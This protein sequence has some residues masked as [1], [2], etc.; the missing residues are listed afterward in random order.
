MKRPIPPFSLL[1]SKA[2]TILQKRYKRSFANWAIVS[3]PDYAPPELNP[4]LTMLSENEQHFVNVCGTSSVQA[5]SEAAEVADEIDRRSIVYRRSRSYGH[6]SFF[7]RPATFAACPTGMRCPR[8]NYR[9]L[10]ERGRNATRS[11]S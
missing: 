11:E 9:V 10:R 6:L 3:R 4:E 5:N 2:T 7:R 8:R 1:Y